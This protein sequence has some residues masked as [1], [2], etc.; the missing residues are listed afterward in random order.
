MAVFDFDRVCVVAELGT[1]H[2]AN[3]SMLEKLIKAAVAS[4]A[5][6]I[7]GQVVFADEILHPDAGIVKLPGGDVALF[8]RFKS[9]EQD[10]DFYRFFAEL[11]LSEGAL[12]FFSVFGKRSLELVLTLYK[13]TGGLFPALKIASPEL[14]YYQLIRQAAKCMPLVLSTGVSRLSDMENAAEWVKESGGDFMF[15]H[16]VTSYPAP[17]EDYN[18][19][20]LPHLSAVFGCPMGIS[21]HSRDAVLVPA[22]AVSQGAVMI[23]KHFC[24][25]RSGEGLDDPIALTPDDFYKMVKAVR[26][27]E[28]SSP[29]DTIKELT[30]VYGKERVQ[31]VIGDGVKKL[32]QSERVN[33]GRTN[34]SIHAKRNIKKGERLTGDAV[35]IV[36]TEKKLN[37][38]IAPVFL[39]D[40]LGKIVARDIKSGEGIVWQDFMMTD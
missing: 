5:D 19:S 7:K 4:G 37:P 25:E 26:K 23:E 24:L 20:L 34:R 16:C 32:A 17:E 18:L 11:V 22:L 29:E 33:Y 39:D 30:A 40:I 13:D 28:T 38:G 3:R 27:A 35:C 2:N 6:W 12:P 31:A 15:L 9:L 8:D 21:D 10:Y 1:S 14:N 36:R